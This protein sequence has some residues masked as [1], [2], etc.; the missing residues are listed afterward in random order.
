MLHYQYSVA[1]EIMEK[2]DNGGIE[3]LMTYD[4]LSLEHQPHRPTPWGFEPLLRCDV[5][6]ARR[7]FT[8]LS[9]FR[10]WF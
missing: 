5:F 8:S 10:R 9:H 6:F 3:D 7:Q 4:R 1:L 2:V